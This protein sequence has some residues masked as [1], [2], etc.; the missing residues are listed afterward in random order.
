MRVRIEQKLNTGFCPMMELY[1]D[2]KRE[3]VTEITPD[4]PLSEIN[5]SV[6]RESERLW[7]E[8]EADIE[9]IERETNYGAVYRVAKVRNIHD[10][11]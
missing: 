1:V 6:H 9:I 8:F 11:I 10:S 4:A 3:Y 2:D 7:V 5:I